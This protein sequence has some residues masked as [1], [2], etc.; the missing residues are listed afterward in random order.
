MFAAAWILSSETTAAA[1]LDAASQTGAPSMVQ[2][3]TWT[4]EWR[5]VIFSDEYRLCLQHQGGHIRVFG[6]Q[7]SVSF[8]A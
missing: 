1:T 2:R 5:D 7:I 8:N 6:H 4:P 3:R